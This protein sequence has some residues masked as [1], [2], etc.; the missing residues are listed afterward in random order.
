LRSFFPLQPQFLLHSNGNLPQ[1]Q[2]QSYQTSSNSQLTIKRHD[3]PLNLSHVPNLHQS[4]FN[5]SL[6]FPIQHVRKTTQ[7]LSL[8]FSYPRSVRG[9]VRIRYHSCRFLHRRL[10]SCNL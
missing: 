9:S 3:N 7:H 1:T 6:N 8:N 5:L 10:Q 4:F 2:S